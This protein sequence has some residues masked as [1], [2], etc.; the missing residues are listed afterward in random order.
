MNTNVTGSAAVKDIVIQHPD[1]RLV[2]EKLGIDYC[3][4]GKMPLAQAAQQAGLPTD[5][6]LADLNEALHAQEGGVAVKDWAAASATELAEHIEQTHHVFMKQQLPRLAG[7]LDKTL[8][9]H[10][11]RQGEMLKQLKHTFV[12][13]KTDIEMHLAKEE[14]ILFPLIRQMETY[15]RGQ[16]PV[17][18]PRSGT[19]ANPV[20]QMEF[21]H[22]QAGQFLAQIR[23]ITSDF[24]PPE[25]TC[26]TFRALCDG[27]RDLEADMH[28]HIHLENN[29]LFPKAVE[30]E[31]RTRR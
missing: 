26:E 9:A 16:G 5:R 23:T 2:L 17:T 27:L 4:G 15:Q 8:Q 25:D 12:S 24:Q 1:T 13:L 14:Q 11:Q 19:V 22:D 29:I 20:G 28:Q 3:C 21:E 30:L 31:A 10:G 18:E 7:L 6:V